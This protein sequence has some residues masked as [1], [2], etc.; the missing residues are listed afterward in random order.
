[1]QAFLRRSS[2]F[3]HKCFLPRVVTRY[4]TT[5]EV[6]RGSLLFIKLQRSACSQ[7]KP[8]KECLRAL[9]L[10]KVNQ[11]QVFANTPTIQGL[12]YKCRDVLTVR[13]V[14]TAELFPEGTEH[15]QY[16]YITK[17]EA[18]E[19]K[20]KAEKEKRLKMIERK[21]ELLSKSETSN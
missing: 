11:I 16:R 10:R 1:M 18:I 19:M 15:I 6:P 13:R 17:R 9:K 7:P 3:T 21:A 4:Y 14:S 20:R 8:I 2:S 12:V 5:E